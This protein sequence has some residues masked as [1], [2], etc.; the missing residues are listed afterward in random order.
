MG[1]QSFRFIVINDVNKMGTDKCSLGKKGKC[2]LGKE[3]SVPDVFCSNLVDVLT[4][5]YYL[6]C[7]RFVSC[8]VVNKLSFSQ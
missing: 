1:W 4:R 7:L 3:L 6:D 5:S 8:V 2:L